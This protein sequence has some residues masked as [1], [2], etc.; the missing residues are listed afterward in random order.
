VPDPLHPLHRHDVGACELPLPRE[1][2][3]VA[4]AMRQERQ[5]IGGWFRDTCPVNPTLEQVERG[6][7][8]L[9][10]FVQEWNLPLNPEDLDELAYAVLVHHDSEASRDEV[11]AAVRAQIADSRQRHQEMLEAMRREHPDAE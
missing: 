5:R 4:F 6:A 2:E 11:E 9:L 7:G 10:P 1:L 8:A 3:P